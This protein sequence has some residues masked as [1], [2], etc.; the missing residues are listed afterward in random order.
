MCER[1]FLPRWRKSDICKVVVE[2]SSGCDVMRAA[3]TCPAVLGNNGRGKC[4]LIGGVL[5]AMKYFTRRGL[6]KYPEPLSCTSR[7]SEWV[8]P[9][10]QSVAARRYD[11][12]NP[13]TKNSTEEKH[14][15]ITMPPVPLM[16][17]HSRCC[18]KVFKTACQLVLFSF[19]IFHGIV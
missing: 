11:I 19:F 18:V 14:S 10:N 9:R 6:Q 4:N 12:L 8:V 13:D 16:K 2:F 17:Q 5:F 7:L 15:S 1:P 3:C